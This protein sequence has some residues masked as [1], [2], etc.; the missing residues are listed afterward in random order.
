MKQSNKQLFTLFTILFLASLVLLSVSPKAFAADYVPLAP[1][2][3]TVPSTGCTDPTAANYSGDCGT[4]LPTYLTG[5]FKIGIAAAGVLA[6]LMIVY[7]G[8]IYLSTDAITGKEE[9]RT[10]IGRAIGGLLLALAAYIILNTINPALV[11]LNLDFGPATGARG[12][13]SAPPPLSETEQLDKV[14]AEVNKNL[15]DTKA[16]MNTLTTAADARQKALDDNYNAG[17]ITNE[18]YK[19]GTDQVDAAYVEAQAIADYNTALDDILL[20][21]THGVQLAQAG[22]VVP[23]QGGFGGGTLS[24]AQ[25]LAQAQAQG[26]ITTITGLVNARVTKLQYAETNNMDLLSR[27]GAP[28]A[29][30]TELTAK[31][32]SWIADI[33][34]KGA[35]AI[36]AIQAA[37]TN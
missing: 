22:R 27:S 37:G 24:T 2:P 25:K 28:E 4:N 1:I 8:F 35:A 23:G 26:V 15:T 18:E 5:I 29:T 36:A 7:G 17:N 10:Y 19:K 13:L 6:F 20:A 11:A 12:G 33:K 34:T 3:G 16:A 21:R 30:V 31:Y 14:I 9:G 32:E